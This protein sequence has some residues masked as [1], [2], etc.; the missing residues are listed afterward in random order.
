MSTTPVDGLPHRFG[1]QSRRHAEGARTFAPVYT[2][3]LR[4]PVHRL[5]GIARAGMNS[6]AQR[7][8]NAPAA[9]CGAVGV[10][11][12]TDLASDAYVNRLAS[13]RKR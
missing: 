3:R 2:E 1:V 11:F 9:E 5:D 13:Q 10:L 8:S 12:L 4:K 6:L 7:T